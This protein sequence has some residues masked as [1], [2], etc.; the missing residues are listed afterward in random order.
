[1]EGRTPP[2]GRR[3]VDRHATAD[4]GESEDRRDSSGSPGRTRP[5]PIGI[6]GLRS[7]ATR[8]SAGPASPRCCCRRR[9]GSPDREGEFDQISIAA[10]DGVTPERAAR[11]D[12]A[13]DASPGARARPAR[14][15]PSGRRATS[16]ATSASFGS[17]CSCSPAYRCSWA[18]F[19]IFNTFSITVAQR[20]REFGDAAHARRVAPRRSCRA[21]VGRR[22]RSGCSARPPASLGGIG[23]AYGHQRAVQ[24]DRR[25]TC[26]T[27]GT[28]VATRTVIVSLHRRRGRDDGRGAVPG[29]ARH[30][31]HPL[32]ALREAEL[33]DTKRRGRVALVVADRRSSCSAWR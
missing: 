23:F 1:M 15:R 5:R 27:P 8:A 26:R 9:S 13:G 28:V 14:R 2:V 24:G 12:R 22:S 16:R 17:R 33:Q 20:T 4:T 32:A 21:S 7:W 19:L 31:R 30:A 18:S 11:P 3:G 25:S 29:A 10:A 6:V